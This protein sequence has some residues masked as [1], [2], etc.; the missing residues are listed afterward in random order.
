MAAK[1]RWSVATGDNFLFLKVWVLFC[2]FTYP[3]R[4]GRPPAS[5]RPQGMCFYRRKVM[6]LR[7][8]HPPFARVAG[9]PK[10]ISFTLFSRAPEVL[11][12]YRDAPGGPQGISC[13]FPAGTRSRPCRGYREYKSTF[14]T[15]TFSFGVWLSMIEHCKSILLIYSL[16]YNQLQ[17]LI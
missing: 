8:A 2:F 16:I 12:G 4:P 17:F 6:F 11:S 15:D 3:A 14:L 13:F 9:R 1:R 5:G 7:P 10:G